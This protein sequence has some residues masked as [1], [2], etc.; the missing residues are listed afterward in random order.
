MPTLSLAKPYQGPLICRAD[1]N[2]GQKQDILCQKHHIDTLFS[3][4]EELPP[5]SKE[6]ASPQRLTLLRCLTRKSS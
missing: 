6:M 4:F 3:E 1:M 2:H 5:I